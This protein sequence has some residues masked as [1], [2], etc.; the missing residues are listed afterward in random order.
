MFENKELNK[1]YTDVQED[2]KAQL[3]SEE[4]GTNPEQIFTDFALAL[5]SDAGETEN[6][7]L[8]YDE[9]ISKR[10]VEHK[11]NAYALYENYETLDLFITIYNAES[12]IQPVTK[13]D[14]EKAIDRVAK[15]FRNAIY[16]DYVNELE[17]SSEIFDLAQTLANVPEVKE[18]LTRVN[19]FLLTNGE[20]KADLKST[21]KV[22]GYPVFYRVI[23]INYLFNLSEKSRVP[24]EIDFESNGIS[25]PCI[26]SQ[27]ENE[28]Y[29]SYLAIIPG[30]ALATIY[31]QYGPRLLEQNVRSFLQFTGKINKGIRTTILDEP[32]MFLAFN[33]GIAATAEE[34]EIIDL[35]DS[36][37][38][39]IGFV[40][41]FQIVNGGQTTASIYHTWKKN[42]ADISKIFV[43][44]KLTIIKDRKNFAEIVGRIAE[45]A[46]TQNRV[47]ASDLSSNRANHV[48][49]EKLSRTIW[50]PPKAGETH[51]TRWFY[52]RS[53]G[54]YKNERMRYGITPSRRKQF[55]KQNP[56]SQMFTKELLAKFINTYSEVYYGKK[57]VIGPHFVVR[58]SQKNY[59]QFLN[60]N[61]DNKPDNIYF[62]DAVALAILF[63]KAEQLYGIKP[64]AIGDMRYITVPYSIA[65]LGFKLNYQLDL[66]RIWKTQELSELLQKKLYEIMVKI[67]DFI[68]SN[69]PGSLYGEWAKKEECW[70]TIKQNDLDISLESL[71][72]DLASKTTIKRKRISDDET[73]QAE[74]NASIERIRSVHPQTWKKIEKWGSETEN[75][76]QYQSN[77]AN[78][79]GNKV[80]NNRNLSEI[81]RMQGESILDIVSENAPELFF[82]MEKFF[83]EDK[84]TKEN[85]QEITLELVKEIVMWDKKNKRLKPF[86]YR[87]MADLAE[88]KKSLTD[89]NKFIAGLNLKK[90]KKY[91]FRE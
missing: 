86:E 90:V 63:K 27:S 62:E 54:Q 45:Y 57:L 79:I 12:T 85:E 76:S 31:E 89:R 7:R 61:F 11:V 42:N 68:K 83:D 30:E 69:A 29:Q 18:F 73:A 64:N 33:N 40:K 13:A 87:F 55:D 70:T 1:F 56:R 88:G 21:D 24:I 14:A 84:K 81:E 65:W 15:F 43:Q 48:I 9:K 23:D 52:E 38:K 67:E 46:N 19:I 20:V 3:L 4:E 53:R 49:L 35:P 5:L 34:V 25:I 72:E 39:A 22:A 80:K 10:G 47:S 77:M 78:T 60:Y 75:L 37:G 17:E 2:I 8:C 41:D 26:E 82:D 6:Y 58:G 36:K 66:Y 50:A 74:I 51:Q 28:D 59:A 91:G 32:H 71:K 44:L 16:K